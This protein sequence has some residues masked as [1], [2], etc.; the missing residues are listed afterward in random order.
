MD[1]TAKTNTIE[2]SGARTADAP[3]VAETLRAFWRHKFLLMTIVVVVTSLAA[4]AAYQIPPRYTATARI[5]INPQSATETGA[6]TANAARALFS[7]ATGSRMS[8][9]SEI[10]VMKSDQLIE[11]MIVTE[12]L[13]A[14]PE[15]NPALQPGMFA[16]LRDL[17]A[18]K[19][20]IKSMSPL[21]SDLSDKE[22]SERETKRIVDSVR[23][24]M[25]IR[26]P[27][28]A[29]VV[30]IQF[31]MKNASKA[32]RLANAFVHIYSEDRL[33]RAAKGAANT[34][35]W[36]DSR[37][38]ELEENLSVSER[39]VA[40]FLAARRL[41]DNGS[42]P[43]IDRRVVELGK[44]LSTAQSELAEK[45]V[46]LRQL[47]KISASGKGLGSTLEV[48]R[49]SAVQRLRAQET[50]L[51]RR[52]AELD[53]RFGEKHPT[54]I[55]L[56]A[57]VENTRKQ[58]AAEEKRIVGAL[59][60]ELRV[61]Q[62]AVASVRDQLQTVDIER[63]ASNEDRVEFLQMRRDALSNRKLYEMF[64]A[65]SK[66]A[67]QTSSLKSDPVQMISPAKAPTHPSAPRKPLIIAFGFFI[68]IGFG[69]ALVLVIERMDGGFRSVTQVERVLREAT[70][71]VVP[72][73]RGSERRRNSVHDIVYDDSHSPY[74]EAIRS[75]RTSL[76][77]ANADAP[78][79]VVLVASSQSGDGKTSLAISL[80][81]LSATASIE[82][83]VL[84][85]DGDLRKPSVAPRI[86]A[87]PTKGLI[88]LFSGEA[89]LDEVIVTD[90]KSGLHVLPATLGTPNP[91]ELL[92]S[93]HMRDLLAK[94]R[95]SYEMIIID[96]PALAAVSDARV[97]AHYADT[98]IFVVR[99]EGTK[100][101]AAIEA[102]KQL[103]TA[104]ARIAGVVLQQVNVK[105]SASYG[106]RETAA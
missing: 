45:R 99:W 59:A 66:Q 24:R 16:S 85:I 74:V 81:R 25:V 29:N 68:S 54:M 51:I 42:S 98:T 5:L 87:N 36:L 38:A 62:A 19:W 21:S 31:E 61:A 4:Y 13:A 37:I 64:V 73:I 58:I 57:E 56:R 60:N 94:L 23:K 3:P 75:L 43:T 18:V 15:F 44:R 2:F 101:H 10:E 63:A 35:L 14:D 49:S 79:K 103:T 50:N 86:G 76:L 70:L 84:L 102:M 95:S 97:L 90:D 72:R 41:D 89:S 69:L 106:Y 88:H 82:G 47:R 27:G 65:K 71:G 12:N 100:Q 11:K 39:K 32:A 7:G 92:N 91:P 28:L 1:G 53:T 48:Q 83:R 40:E 30:A 20:L 17:T 77:V 6:N 93:T 22:R 52:A 55:N 33:S 26:P 9:Y 46:R 67:E 78:P 96:S 8:I 105:K 34:R 104:G 80:A